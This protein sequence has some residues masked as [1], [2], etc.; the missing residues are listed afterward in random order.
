MIYITAEDKNMP[1]NSNSVILVYRAGLPSVAAF[2]DVF[3]INGK[4]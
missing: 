2:Y 3:H 4:Y 1:H